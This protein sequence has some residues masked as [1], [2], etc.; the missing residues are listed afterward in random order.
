MYINLQNGVFFL[1][2]GFQKFSKVD[3]KRMLVILDE[4]RILFDQELI[5]VFDSLIATHL[6]GARRSS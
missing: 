3:W 1:L 5:D 4:L 6:V 2:M